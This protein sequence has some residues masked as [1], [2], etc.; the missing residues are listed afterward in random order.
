[1]H[2]HGANARS[3]LRIFRASLSS[4]RGAPVRKVRKARVSPLQ[5]KLREVVAR[6]DAEGWPLVELEPPRSLLDDLTPAD[7]P[8]GEVSC[9]RE[10]GE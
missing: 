7:C 1:M 3:V 9:E 6:L 8:T 4:K 5:K 2:N 10:V